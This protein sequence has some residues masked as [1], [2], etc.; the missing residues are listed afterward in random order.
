MLHD[1]QNEHD[2]RHIAIDQVG[3]Q[4][5]RHPI[6]LTQRDGQIQHSI[7][8]V[9]MTVGLSAHSRATHMSRFVE[10]LSKPQVA[11]FDQCNIIL[12]QMTQSLQS[13]S[14]YISMRFPYFKLKTAPVSG[15][16]SLLDYNVIFSAVLQESNYQFT[17]QVSVPVTTL[18]PCS[19]A[20]AKQGAHNQRSKVTITAKTRCPVWIEDFIDRVESQASCELYSLV[21]R[22]DEK[23]ITEHAYNNPKFVED[24]TRDVAI[25]LKSDKRLGHY[26]V[27]SVSLESIHNHAVYARIECP[28]A[29]NAN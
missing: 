26:V 15:K 1:T 14:A 28:I 3:I 27:E 19:K 8:E 4:S 22:P 18:C 25:Q 6:V 20:L 24:I 7:A 10:L 23:W 16:Q 5:L 13:Q 12:H 21:K 29:G 17:L 2:T 9:D 11:S